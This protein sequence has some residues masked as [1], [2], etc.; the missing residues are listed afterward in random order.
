MLAVTL[1]NSYQINESV[2]YACITCICD[3]WTFATVDGILYM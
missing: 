1:C 2:I 3:T